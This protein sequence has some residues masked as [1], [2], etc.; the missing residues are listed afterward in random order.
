LVEKPA[1][2]TS[3]HQRKVNM[4]RYIVILA[5]AW[6]TAGLAQAQVSHWAEGMFD[7]LSRDF[8]SV[9]RGPVVSHPFRIVNNTGHHVQIAGIRV[10]CGCT[11]AYALKYSLAP[12]EETA[13]VADMDTSRF[14]NSRTVTIFVTFSQPAWA[15]VRLWVRANSREDVGVHPDTIA[16]GRIKRGSSPEQAVNIFLAGS[17]DYRIIGVV[18]DSNYIQPVC[19]MTAAEAF[20]VKYQ[21][22]ARLRP[23]TPPGRW[24][25]DVWVTTN[26]PAMPRVRI[27]LT[28]EIESA[29]SVSPSNVL[30]GNV[31]T[32]TEAVRK[33]IVRGVEPFQIK[34]VRG[35]DN[36]LR[37]QDSTQKGTVHILTVT[38]RPQQPGQIN[39]TLFIDT[40]LPGDNSIDFTARAYVVP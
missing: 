18:A 10:S 37:V 39:R 6:G 1:R 22:V 34:A 17:P 21:L 8:G 31:K 30:L 5:I 25:T 12:G 40:D 16:Y 32:G 15:E 38:L 7:S 23:D 20:E 33:I 4:Y 26:N 29:L 28:V 13:L 14:Y 36:Q 35:T 24:Y 9:P 27:P 11:T 3:E 19:R 2:A